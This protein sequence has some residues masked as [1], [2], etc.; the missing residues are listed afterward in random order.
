MPLATCAR[1]VRT[2]ALETAEAPRAIEDKAGAVS[3]YGMTTADLARFS[4]ELAEL[5]RPSWHRLEAFWAAC[6]SL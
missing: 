2:Y 6:G 1:C 5:V 4:E 3:G